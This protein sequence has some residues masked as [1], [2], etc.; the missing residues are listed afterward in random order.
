M[1]PRDTRLNT[2]AEMVVRFVFAARYILFFAG[3]FLGASALHDGSVYDALKALVC[4]AAMLAGHAWL[5]RGKKL[6]ECDRALDAMFRG[7]SSG[8]DEDGLAALLS[9]REAL[10]RQRGQP[11]FDPWAVQAVRREINDYVRTHP[12]STRDFD[13]RL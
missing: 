9:R 3:L 1:R 2:P 12:E 11:G 6:A 7:G 8:D 13:G 10:E 5:R 4:F